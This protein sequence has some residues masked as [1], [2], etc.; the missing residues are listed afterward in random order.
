MLLLSA[1]D[2]AAT[3]TQGDFSLVGTL[4][5]RESGRWGEGGA[6]DTAAPIGSPVA[7]TSSG[8]SFDF[9]RWDLVQARRV[10]DI[11]PDYQVVKNYSL[12]G[13]IDTLFIQSAD[14][15]AIYRGWYDAYP[16]LKTNGNAQAFHDWTPYTARQRTEEFQRDDLR[17]YYLQAYVNDSL[18]FR[19]GKQQV[20]WTEA[21]ALSGT[22]LINTNDLR[23]HWVHF[24]N[25]E[26][27]RRGIQMVKMDW[28]L[29]DGFRTSNNMFEGFWIP[30]DYE[31][32]AVLLNVRDARSPFITRAPI[33]TVDPTSGLPGL[34]YNLEGVPM[35]T[36]TLADAP[37]FPLIKVP[38]VIPGVSPNEFLDFNV[39]SHIRTPPKS[40]KSSEFG[41]RLSSLLPVGDGLQLSLVYLWLA[42][43]EQ[44]RFDVTHDPSAPFY[45]G[46][47]GKGAVKLGSGLYILPGVRSWPNRPGA[48]PFLF[49]P[50]PLLAD[51][52]GTVAVLVDDQVIRHHLLGATGTYYDKNLT[53]I[54]YRFDFS[55]APKFPIGVSNG[56]GDEN[57]P[58]FGHFNPRY[59]SGAAWTEKGIAI[60]GFD[61][62]TYIPYI[63][64]QHTF[65]VFQNTLT[66]Y[67]DRPD[68]AVVTFGTPNDRVRE[69]SDL[70]SLS[71]LDWF[72]GG[73]LTALNSFS[74]DV[75]DN[76]GY[77][78]T[79][80][81]YRYS[82]HVL[83]AINTAWYLGRSGRNTDPYLFSRNQRINE[84]EFRVTYEI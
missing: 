25:P 10:A 69:V 27:L 71:A 7:P 46:A 60:V 64:K 83:L 57:Q 33:G 22:D 72:L 47:R 28:T 6:R 9:K 54:V 23:Y 82:P 17:E 29:P 5:T 24:E 63:S 18:T 34:V 15:F 37:Q 11:R 55:Y 53:D 61:R 51:R 40:I 41:A 3:I 30:G 1:R 59:P 80:N 21:D 74:W 45:M 8:G 56:F 12:L 38:T 65:I 84:V 62:P 19:I 42:R 13:R 43:V 26:D 32:S 44:P 66:W 49:P 68:N 75:D 2:S 36:T 70:V 78:F 81:S 14:L 31:G 16:N 67:P 48:L 76:V 79:L 4:S 58:I 77:F 50:S 52:V 39:M 73:R 20:I 35:R